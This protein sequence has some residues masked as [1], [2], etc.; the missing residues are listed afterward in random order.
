MGQG[1]MVILHSRLHWFIT[2]SISLAVWEYVRMSAGLPARCTYCLHQQ[3]Q[4]DFH[5]N[6]WMWFTR[7]CVAS[8][9]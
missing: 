8:A 4:Q 9:V 2:A 3:W 1:G 5:G 6:Y 7:F